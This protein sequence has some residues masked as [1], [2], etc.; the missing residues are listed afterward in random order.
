MRHPFDLNPEELAAID[1]S[2]TDLD[3]SEELTPEEAAQVNGSLRHA[4]TR[5][6]GEE[7]GYCGTPAPPRPTPHPRPRPYPICPPE[8]TTLALGEEGGDWATTLALGEEGGG[9]ITTMAIGEE[10]GLPIK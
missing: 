10:G 9:E 6:L 2:A 5:A 4:T 7:G 3:F 1:F 8:V